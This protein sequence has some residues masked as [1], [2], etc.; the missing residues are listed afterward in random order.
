MKSVVHTISLI[1][2]LT[3]PRLPRPRSNNGNYRPCSLCRA[4]SRRRAFLCFRQFNWSKAAAQGVT[5]AALQG[6]EPP[7]V[8][9]QVRTTAPGGAAGTQ[10]PGGEPEQPAGRRVLW[11]L[12]RVHGVA[13]PG[14]AG[15]RAAGA[16]TKGEAVPRETHREGAVRDWACPER[17]T[18]PPGARDPS[19][20]SCLSGEGSTTRGPDPVDNVETQR[21]VCVSFLSFLTRHT[22]VP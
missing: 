15:G 17:T 13:G 10:A 21:D 19:M 3:N 9:A 8:P 2:L 20:T 5:A 1:A 7:S 16:G 11:A 22:R 6:R 12:T 4:S 14:P 18:L